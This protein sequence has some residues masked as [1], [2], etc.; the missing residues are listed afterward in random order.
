MKAFILSEKDLEDLCTM[1]DRDPSYGYHGGS[2]TSISD[3]QK[4]A[5][6]EAH[7]FFNYQVRTWIDNVKK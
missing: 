6:Q 3:Q 4:Q 7:R 1:L 2:S 5:Y